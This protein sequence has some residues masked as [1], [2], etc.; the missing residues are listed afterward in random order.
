ML[1]H[2]VLEAIEAVIGEWKCHHELEGGPQSCV[3]SEPFE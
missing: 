3:G 1:A 2:E